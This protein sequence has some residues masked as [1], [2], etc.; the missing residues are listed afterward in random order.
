MSVEHLNASFKLCCERQRSDR[1][2]S[3]RS[4]C[5][6]RRS[7]C[8]ASAS[9]RP[10][11]D[12][13]LP[14]VARR[15]RGSV[16]ARGVPRAGGAQRATRWRRAAATLGMSCS[17][18]HVGAIAADDDVASARSRLAALKIAP[19][20]GGSGGP[21]RAD[22]AWSPR[23]GPPPSRRSG[24]RARAAARTPGRRAMRSSTA[25]GR[26]ASRPSTSRSP[27]SWSRAAAAARTRS[28][29][30]SPSTTSGRWTRSSRVARPCAE[31]VGLRGREAKEVGAVLLP[32]LAP[33]PRS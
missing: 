11:G 12:R 8:A 29:R 31:A 33:P 21:I 24:P 32:P 2:A 25:S 1:F 9:A 4:R 19:R 16:V 13:F 10:A 14:C 3:R 7:S 27:W 20:R 30:S 17:G 26:A 22:H 5:R 6:G 28:A 23:I 18:A 15:A